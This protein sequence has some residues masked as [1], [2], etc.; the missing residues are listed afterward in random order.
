MV[1]TGLSAVIGSWKIMPTSRPRI[2]QSAGSSRPARSVPA[3]LIEPLHWL[4]CGSNCITE[5][6]VIDLPDPDS[7]TTPRMRPGSSVRSMSCNTVLP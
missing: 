2:R 5:S 1:R 3:T 7:P 6:A 4:P